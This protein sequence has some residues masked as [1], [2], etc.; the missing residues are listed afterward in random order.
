[1]QPKPLDRHAIIQFIDGTKLTLE[2]P[3]Q[4]SGSSTALLESLKKSLESERLVIEADGRLMIIPWSNVRWVE[5]VPAPESLPF[6]AI[7]HARIVP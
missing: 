3:K 1:M 2:F 4:I 7:R 5:V 6:G